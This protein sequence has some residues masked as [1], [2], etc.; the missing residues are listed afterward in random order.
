MKRVY[1]GL[2]RFA[3]V[4]ERILSKTIIVPYRANEKRA[5][6]NKCHRYD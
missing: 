2:R 6:G 3:V 5:V 1:D 4:S